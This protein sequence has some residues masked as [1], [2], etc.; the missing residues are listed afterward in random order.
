MQ[1]ADT[2]K[3]RILIT[4]VAGV[5]GFHLARRLLKG[6]KGETEI[7][8]IDSLTGFY[9]V[10]LKVA[11]L[12]ELGVTIG[13]HAS[14]EAWGRGYA[15]ESEPAF[16]F[17]RID[18]ADHEAMDKLMGE[19]RFDVVFHL[20]AQASARYSTENPR[21]YLETNLVGFFNVLDACRRSEVG[22]LV[23]A[24]SS[25][26][27]G[28]NENVPYNEDDDASRP[29][30]FYA[31]TKRSNEL[32]AHS[33]AAVYGLRVTGLRFFSVY[34]PWGRPD[35]AP[36]LFI[37]AIL[38]GRQIK[39]YNQGD[40]Y[41]DFTYIDYVVEGIVSLMEDA[42]DEKFS[43]YNVGN[44]APVKLTD[45][46]TTIEEVAGREAEKVMLPMQA[47][48]MYR[49]YA[50]CGA[51]LRATGFTPSTALKEGIGKTVAWFKDYY[52]LK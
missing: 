45:Y 29:V 33:Y 37:D 26:V 7:V 21:E 28:M 30:S 49:T 42:A 22:H 48:D 17:C 51:L 16:T 12:R 41:R 27:Y 23:F 44:S 47:G 18:I 11:R 36:Y 40:M 46:I 9:D 24:S 39:V 5:I 50:D 3:R 35:M 4:G 10:S 19:T 38:H 8:G 13:S 52:K 43:I 2:H 6:S 15:S 32:M 31:A 14:E 34:G 25:S 1:S 20:A